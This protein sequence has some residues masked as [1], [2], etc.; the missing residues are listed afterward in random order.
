MS[1][2]K[3][4]VLQNNIIKI[5]L[6]DFFYNFGLI[7]AIYILYF[8]FLTYSFQ[9]IGLF[10]AITSITII[11]TEL[12][13]GSL[14]DII[15]RR[16]TVILGNLSM[17]IFA[18]VLGLGSGGTYILLVAG[19]FS[20]LD[21]SFR[22]GA[23]TALLYDTM[24]NLNRADNFLKVSGKIHALSLISKMAGMILGSFLFLINPRIPYWIWSGFLIISIFILIFV[25]EP[26]TEKI[27]LKISELWKHMVTGVKYIFKNAS[28][29]WLTA[30]FL[31]ANAFP[32]AYWDI[33][34]QEHMVTLDLPTKWIGII[35]ALLTGFSSLASYFI[36][37]IEQRLGEK[38]LLLL[39]IVIQSILFLFMIIT[40]QWYW[41]LIILFLL[42]IIRNFSSLLEENYSNKLIPSSMRAGVLS[43]ASFLR[44]GLFG[45]WLIIWM[46]GVLIDSIGIRYV[47]L[48]SATLVLFFGLT[49]ILL[50]K[51]KN[52][53]K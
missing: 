47:L 50:R 42:T 32:E 40:K 10:E 18:L 21:F 44:N 11:F 39:I 6:A 46:Y 2:I 23:R 27:Q 37:E 26:R 35:F 13:T 19:I 34:S 12:A 31:V 25:K 38:V 48:I 52:N 51:Y 3:P 1:S 17:L 36:S 8:R 33:Y 28:L 4:N 30:F 7:W 20:G 15:G 24:V 9:D 41:L 45:G 14:A 5:A 53:H 16:N 22:S 29:L 49:M 43:A